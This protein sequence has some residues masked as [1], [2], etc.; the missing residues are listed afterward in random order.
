MLCQEIQMPLRVFISYSHQDAVLAEKIVKAI[1]ANG[2]TPMWDKNFQFGFG[3][4]QM[5]KTFISHSHVF[6]PIITESSNSRGW[7]HQ[8]IGYA[9]ALNIPVPTRCSRGI[10]SGNDL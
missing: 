6:L 9:V 1:I 8:E 4:H 3:F 7:V 2:M 10:A 5:I